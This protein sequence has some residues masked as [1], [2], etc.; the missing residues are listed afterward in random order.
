LAFGEDRASQPRLAASG[1]SLAKPQRLLHMGFTLMA[2]LGDDEAP[3]AM[4]GAFCF[5]RQGR[6]EL[7][8]A[9]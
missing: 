5:P 3:A 8:H 7:W 2:K 9:D 6:V 4:R 1:S